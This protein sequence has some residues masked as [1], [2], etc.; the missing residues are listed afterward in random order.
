MTEVADTVQRAASA[1]L[2]GGSGAALAS[3]AVAGAQK[4]VGLTPDEW[5]LVFAAVGAGVAV[6]GYFTSLWFQWQHLKLT[7]AKAQADPEE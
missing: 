5:T 6:T 1:S 3:G 2:Y 7:R 4:Y